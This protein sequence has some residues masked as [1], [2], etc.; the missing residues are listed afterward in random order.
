MSKEK[1]EVGD[2]IN[3]DEFIK[4]NKDCFRKGYVAMDSDGKWW[5]Y[6]VKPFIEHKDDKCWINV[7]VFC[8]LFCFDIAPVEDW[9]SSLRKVEEKLWVRLV[10]IN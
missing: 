2:M 10:Q 7:T 4:R 9:T 8:G 3:I 5:W 6:E 1:L